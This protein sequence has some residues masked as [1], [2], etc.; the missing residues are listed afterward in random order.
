MTDPQKMIEG[1]QRLKTANWFP[2]LNADFDALIHKYAHP[3][4]PILEKVPG[5]TWA[6]KA[7]AIGVSRQNLYVWMDER[8][9]P[10]PEQADSIAKLTGI[11]AAHIRANGYQETHNDTGRKSKKTAPRMAK[12]AVGA[13]GRSHRPRLPRPKRQAGAGGPRTRTQRS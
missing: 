12:A 5:E 3:M 8:F 6:D 1:L 11:P 7:R 10:S 4:R 13:P 9:R 2:A